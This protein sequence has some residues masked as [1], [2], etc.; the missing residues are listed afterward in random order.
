MLRCVVRTN[1]LALGDSS[2]STS[3]TQHLRQRLEE[4]ERGLQQQHT[5]NNWDSSI[6]FYPEWPH[7]TIILTCILANTRPKSRVALLANRHVRVKTAVKPAH[8]TPGRRPIRSY[9]HN[10]STCAHSELPVKNVRQVLEH[11]AVWD[12]CETGVGGCEVGGGVVVLTRSALWDYQLQVR[13]SRTFGCPRFYATRSHTE[14]N[15]ALK[16]W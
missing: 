6:M 8:F 7:R 16:I 12:V 14:Q 1:Q 4:F 3:L 10:A 5:H 15:L 2:H 13:T 9:S 11:G